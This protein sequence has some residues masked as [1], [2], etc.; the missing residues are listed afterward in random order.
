[1]G[2][3]LGD[4]EALPLALRAGDALRVGVAS[5]TLAGVSSLLS[6]SASLTLALVRVDALRVGLPALSDDDNVA[7]CV[8]KL[9]VDA[10]V[11]QRTT[12]E[13][14]DSERG[15]VGSVVGTLRWQRHPSAK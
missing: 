4:V 14:S 7:V 11:L 9:L 5:V 8:T 12:D 1:M 6:D 2:V 3:L 13:L 10:D 15:I